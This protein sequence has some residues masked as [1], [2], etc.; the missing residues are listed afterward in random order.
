MQEKE[1]NS[2]KNNMNKKNLLTLII[3]LTLILSVTLTLP[4][5]TSAA[6]KEYEVYK[7]IK[8]G[9]TVTEVS[10]LIYGKTYKSYLKKGDG[11]TIFK[12]NPLH[13]DVTKDTKNYEFGFYANDKD[14][15]S[16]YSHR[17]TVS[18][19][20]KKNSKNVYV[21]WKSYSPK[22][23]STKKFYKNKKPKF[24]MTIGQIDKILFGEGLG[25]FEH[26]YSEDL[27][28]FGYIDINK[29]NMFPSKVSTIYYQ[30]KSYSSKT[31][32]LLYFVYD[33]KKKTYIYTE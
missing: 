23:P 24:G 16:W 12:K 10:K 33:Y 20:N 6:S 11:I 5:S 26:L 18:F 31:D 13:R 9:M 14:S 8:H 4:K 7:Q 1:D 30:A 32:Y 2:V 3:T 28:N 27:T 17:L 22:D 19:F 15:K 25:A 21:G 29:K